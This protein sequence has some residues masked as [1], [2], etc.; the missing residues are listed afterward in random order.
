MPR[1]PPAPPAAGQAIQ[2]SRPA[3]QTGKAALP[4]H[5]PAHRFTLLCKADR[6]DVFETDAGPQILPA[7]RVLRHQPGVSGVRY[8]KGAPDGDATHAIA[9]LKRKGWVEIPEETECQ[10]F[11][12]TVDAYNEMFQG[13]R[14][15]VWHDVWNQPYF[16]GDQLYWN[17]DEAGYHDFLRMVLERFLGGKIDP[18]VK[19]AL[20]VKLQ[21]M[22]RKAA[23]I[24]SPMSR[25]M[26][27]QIGDRLTVF[28]AA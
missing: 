21:T 25:P 2:S 18:N 13:H 5:A 8:I 24:D 10:A 4:R 6:F 3:R 20:Q 28:E 7:L 26:A 16:L 1:R 19:R 17:R 12:K 14:G 15:P 23:S 27:S 9:T 22:A 11:G